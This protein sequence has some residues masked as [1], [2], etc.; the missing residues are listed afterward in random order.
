MNVKRILIIDDDLEL[1]EELSDSL[2]SEGYLVEHIQDPI[3]AE[4]LM[5]GG[6]YDAFLLDYK[7]P[8]LSGIDLLKKLKK[9]NVRRQILIISGKPHVEVVLKEENLSDM[10][11]GIIAKPIIFETLLEK[12]REL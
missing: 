11:R 8:L 6:S 12:I 2:R 7:M 5:R 1:C 10:V 4:G 9:D 3:K